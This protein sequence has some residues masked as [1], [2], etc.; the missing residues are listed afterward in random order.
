MYGDLLLDQLGVNFLGPAPL[1][2]ELWHMLTTFHLNALGSTLG[3]WFCHNNTVSRNEK[4]WVEQVTVPHP[5]PGEGQ[6]GGGYRAYVRVRL[7]RRASGSL[8]MAHPNSGGTPL[9]RG[10][11]VAPGGPSAPK[12]LP[13]AP[14]RPSHAA[15]LC[16]NS[17]VWRVLHHRHRARAVGT[18]EGCRSVGRC[19]LQVCAAAVRPVRS[20][21]A[22]AWGRGGGAGG[23]AATV[24]AYHIKPNGS[25][26][27]VHPPPS[28]AQRRARGTRWGSRVSTAVIPW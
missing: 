12:C 15:G 21:K 1:D 27:Q 2:L 14:R 20:I 5:P 11:R 10:G 6:G 28:R 26:A 24:A 25:G 22:L 23:I 16:Q 8:P 4:F 7:R 17:G 9:L 19:I 3:W 18:S 13:P